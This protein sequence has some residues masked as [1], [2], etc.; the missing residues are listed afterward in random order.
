MR[1]HIHRWTILIAVVVT[2]GPGCVAGDPSRRRPDESEPAYH[3][4]MLEAGDFQMG[5]PVPE[6]DRLPM[7][8][9]SDNEAMDKVM[10]RMAAEFAGIE[11][12]APYHLAALIKLGRRSA[13]YLLA[14]LTNE[15]PT[16]FTYYGDSLYFYYVGLR[17]TTHHEELV[18]HT[19]L[20]CD[21]ADFALR[22]IYRVE[23]GWKAGLSHE[24]IE[25]AQRKWRKVVEEN[26]ETSGRHRTIP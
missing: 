11:R 22:R 2:V 19:A 3:A 10:K 6:S 7:S 1:T 15:K 4:R 14:M 23:V 18:L 9:W 12:G 20:L 16:P 26:L 25:G 8:V 21:L 13:P 5:W 24:E 17:P